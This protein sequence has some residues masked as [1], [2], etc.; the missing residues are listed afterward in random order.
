[1]ISDQLNLDEELNRDQRLNRFGATQIT[2][3]IKS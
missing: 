1:M 3:E 2:T